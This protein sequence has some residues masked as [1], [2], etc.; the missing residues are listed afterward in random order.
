MSKRGE[1]ITKRK[2]GRWE[3]RILKGYTQEG[4][5]MYKSLYAYS[6]SEA[7]AKKLEYLMHLSEKNEIAETGTFGEVLS[8]FLQHKKYQ[9]K[10]STFACYSN[11]IEQHLRPEFGKIPLS[12][13]DSNLI[14]NFIA[15]KLTC[16]RKDR[17]GGL[18]GKT[19]RDILM[20]FS[21][22]L[23]YADN[24]GLIKIGRIHYALPQSEKK[25]VNIFT[26]EEEKI[27][28]VYSIASDNC[29]KFGMCL[30]LY[31]GLR[32]GELCA[33]QWKNLDLDKALIY[34]RGTLM[35]I[36]NTDK[37][38]NSKTKI[39]INTPKTS[40]GRR[41]IP[42]PSFLIPKL[43]ELRGA[44]QREEDY[45]LTGTE[46]YIEPSNYYVKYRK[47][48]KEMQLPERSFHTLRHTFATRCVESG[49]DIK[50]LS[51]ILG[52]ADVNITLNR[53]VH[54]SLEHKRMNMEKMS[55]LYQKSIKV[56]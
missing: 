6:Y 7:K 47:W 25:E 4:K 52:H 10:E 20:V 48:L 3:A 43:V 53:Y 14:E 41:A 37:D 51:E 44:N 36:N 11:I 15:E 8:M 1:N 18:S 26:L 28:T 46:K 5:A 33:L 21:L 9:V 35:R 32:I 23:K 56:S 19:V 54:S 38:S 29:Q 40:A 16:G 12:K 22:I 31:T 45:F 39:V 34:V 42:I 27:L 55:T 17:S 30:S 2:D 13:L 49:F 50:T 24:T